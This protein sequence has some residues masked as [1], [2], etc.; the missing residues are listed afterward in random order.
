MIS[1]PRRACLKLD[2]CCKLE[3]SEEWISV[4]ARAVDL[5][6]AKKMDGGLIGISSSCGS[7]QK[8]SVNNPGT[9]QCWIPVWCLQRRSMMVWRAWEWEK[10]GKRA[11]QW[12]PCCPDTL[13]GFLLLMLESAC[14]VQEAL[15]F[16]CLH[17]D[18]EAPPWLYLC[19]YCGFWW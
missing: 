19:S 15:L 11:K 8:S 17:R 12:N 13:W 1:C 3:I 6:V 16:C 5:A 9:A 10:R 14:F 2:R 4:K 7:C 18:V